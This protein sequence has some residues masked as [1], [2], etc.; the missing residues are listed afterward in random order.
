[1]IVY[2]VREGNWRARSFRG[3]AT[4]TPGHIATE[5]AH[6]FRLQDGRIA[7]HWA[8]RDDLAAMQQLHALPSHG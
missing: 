1:V 5:L 2:G 3:V 7:E 4:P 8:V 6:M